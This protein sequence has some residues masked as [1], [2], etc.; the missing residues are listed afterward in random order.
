MSGGR[1]DQVPSHASDGFIDGA[2][3]RNADGCYGLTQL[4]LHGG[5]I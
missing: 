5:E 3:A 1:S 4:A 2:I